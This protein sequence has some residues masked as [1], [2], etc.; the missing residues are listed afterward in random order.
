MLQAV[1]INRIDNVAVALSALAAETLVEVAGMRIRLRAQIPAGHKFALVSL[2][3][4]DEVIKYGFP[5]GRVANPVQP[6]DYLHSHNVR[7]ALSG[8]GD[9]VYAPSFQQTEQTKNNILQGKT[10][11]G[12]R[13][14]DGGVATRNELW[15]L[16]T[17]GCVNAIARALATRM[18]SRLRGR[19]EGVYAFEHPYGC[20]QLGE[21]HEITRR[22]LANLA[23]HPN[24]GGVLIL[25]LGCENNQIGQ[26]MELLGDYDRARIR[27]LVAQDAD[28]E[29]AVGVDLLEELAEYTA[30]FQRESLPVS[31][32]RVGLKCG[33]SDAFS[34][35]TAN[36]L[37]GV[38]SDALCAAGGASALTEVP[39]MFG[40]EGIILNRC[41]DLPTF[42][43]GAGL[44]NA[45]RD[46][47]T[48]H[49]EPV[50]ENPS[51]GNR[52]GGITTLE[53]KSLGCVQKGGSGPVVDILRYG[54]RLG[55]SGLSIVEGPGNDLVAVTNLAAAGCHLIL[56]T[57]GRGNPYGG[58][59]PTIKIS[60]NS[61]LAWRKKNWID[62]DAGVLLG[63]TPMGQALEQFAH[64]VLRIASG[65]L[66]SNERNGCREIAIF[67]S[68]VTL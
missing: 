30:G 16:P 24:A 35:I 56:F 10:F 59:V 25:G 40:A 66:A 58:P 45:F 17:V 48:R 63:D 33:G 14:P 13:R 67:K 5:I 11:Y 2:A 21:D 43:R 44:V 47:Y 6:G 23:L 20:S 27:F 37:L 31:S 64:V 9:F 39:E 46:Y 68:G 51:P 53:E 61:D 12:F 65:E 28:D 36:P 26:F 34:G 32:L 8:Q 55:Q 19:A 15:I 1:Q 50:S 54:E 22:T 4:G 18:A 3:A 41:Q 52:A 7:T 62:F 49:G 57:T 42:E 29:I 60:T 38:F